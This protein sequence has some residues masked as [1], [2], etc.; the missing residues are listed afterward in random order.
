MVLILGPQSPVLDAE[1][2][3]LRDY[4]NRHAGRLL[5]ALEPGRDHGLTDLLEEWGIQVDDVLAVENNPAFRTEAGDLFVRGIS[6]D[7]PITRVLVDARIPLV[8]G[9]ARSVRPDLGRPLDD[10]L[11]VTPLLHT[12]APP[13][14][15]GQVTSWGEVNYRQ[16]P[17]H[18][19]DPRRDLAGPVFLATVAERRV[20]PELRVKVRGGRVVVFGA[21]D[22]VANQRIGTLGNTTLIVNA[23]NWALDPERHVNIPARPIERLKLTLSEQQLFI[24]GLVIVFGPPFVV[25][26]LGLAV[27]FARRR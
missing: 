2:G 23:V 4:L 18:T 10:A 6:P 20:D 25:T 17:P 26:L 8:F 11:V 15:T 16:P 19:F 14:T 13:T 27:Y 24:S 22:F 21:S 5:I 7:H 1:Q 9:A 12:S 3:L